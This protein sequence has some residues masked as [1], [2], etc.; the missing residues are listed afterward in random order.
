MSIETEFGNEASDGQTIEHPTNETDAY[1]VEE[2]PELRPT[3]E[4]EIQAKVDLNHPDG[5]KRG[6]TLAAEERL[7]ARE[8]EIE[9]TRER[10]DRSQTSDRE[11]RTRQ[12]VA[13]GSRRRRHE[14]KRRAGSVDPTQDP[15]AP[16]PRERLERTDLAWV[17]EQAMNLNA[18]LGRGSTAVIAEQLAWKLLGGMGR[19]SAT[20][21]V[22]ESE[23]DRIQAVT[24]I[25]EITKGWREVTVEG[26]LEQLWEPSHP[27]ISQ[28][29]LLADETGRTKLTSWK[30]S[31]QPWIDEGERVRIYD[32]AVS[33]YNGRPSI[34]LT[35]RSRVWFPE[36]ERWWE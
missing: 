5:R 35:S 26:T 22:F 31:E 23:R 30:K 12:A 33:W 6:L 15:G 19:M 1:L 27:S 20:I 2:T 36:R 24:P 29:G 10:M 11:A 34:A 28:V 8:W 9:R 3:V 16:D 32:A 17:N 7:L 14:F 18:R 13:A 4:L 25:D 21:A